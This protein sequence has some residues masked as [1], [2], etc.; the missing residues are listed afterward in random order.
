MR[1][2]NIQVLVKLQLA[3]SYVNLG[4]DLDYPGWTYISV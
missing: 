1:K 3:Y 4:T 2:S